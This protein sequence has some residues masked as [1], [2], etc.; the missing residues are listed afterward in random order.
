MTRFVAQYDPRTKSWRVV[1]TMTGLWTP[2]AWNSTYAGRVAAMCEDLTDLLDGMGLLGTTVY[3]CP[4]CGGSGHGMAWDRDDECPR[5][6]G[7]GYDVQTTTEH[8]AAYAR[9]EG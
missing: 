8:D 2:S 4:E 7:A 1:C 9:Q 6:S 3:P 5:C